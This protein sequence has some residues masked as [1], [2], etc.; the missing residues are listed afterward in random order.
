MYNWRENLHLSFKLLD[1]FITDARYL[2]FLF[3]TKNKLSL[4]LIGIIFIAGHDVKHDW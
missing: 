4:N 1:A 3:F 2:T